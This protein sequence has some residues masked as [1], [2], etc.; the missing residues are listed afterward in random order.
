[1]PKKMKPAM[2]IMQITVLLKEYLNKFLDEVFSPV[3][4]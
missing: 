4:K 1:M 2:T 3:S